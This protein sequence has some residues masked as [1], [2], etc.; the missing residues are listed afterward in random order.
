MQVKENICV[1]FSKERKKLM[2]NVQSEGKINE[3]L[4]CENIC[5]SK[6]KSK[7]IID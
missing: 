2:K 6:W 1:D 7:S 5:F 3:N 4:M